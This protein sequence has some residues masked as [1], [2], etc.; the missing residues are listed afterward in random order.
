MAQPSD[1]NNEPNSYIIDTFLLDTIW[2]LPNLDTSS[3]ISRR[4][5]RPSPIDSTSTLANSTNNVA[6]S[7]T[8]SGSNNNQNQTI[9]VTIVQDTFNPIL[10]AMGLYTSLVGQDDT[11][12]GM[13]VFVATSK[14]VLVHIGG[15]DFKT[16]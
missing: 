14:Q 12:N 5:F 15:I 8:M 10:A 6:I 1:N 9:N 13:T 16:S 2:S 4:T 11:I 3:I 7:S